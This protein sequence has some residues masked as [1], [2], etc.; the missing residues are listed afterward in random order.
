MKPI[1]RVKSKPTERVAGIDVS[2]KTLHVAMRNLKSEI[3]TFEV[4]NDADGHA[5]L[6]RRL[7]E[8]GSPA[9]VVLEAT[10]NY[11]LDAALSLIAA[12]I[13]VMVANPAATRSF[14]NAMMQRAKTDRVDSLALL[15]FA[16]RMEFE[17]WTPPSTAR[18]SLRSYAR[19]IHS[20]TLDVVALQNRVHALQATGTTPPPI[21][22]DLKQAIVALQKRIDA[23]IAEATTLIEAHP[24]LAK[25]RRHVETV[26]GI[27][28]KSAIQLLG[29]LLVLPADMTPNQVVAHAGLDPRPKRSGT[30]VKGRNAISKVG[31]AR[32]RAALYM[33]CLVA[34]QHCPP[35]RAFYQRLVERGK[36]K[37]VA[38]I[39]A[40]RRV[41]IAVWQMIRT[42]QDFDPT[43]FA[44]G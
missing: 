3:S 14:M 10:G 9:R 13:K 30:S 18:V 7:T 37:M 44:A 2:A 15:E 19:H 40:N 35:I 42:G 4:A 1:Q 38:L 12:K 36:L 6:V 21:L 16:E 5:T 8:N 33:P 20:L 26:T 43:R 29:E 25:A 11:S 34:I 27:K 41:L 22:T 32:L 24:D 31:N 23:M 17:P 39:A 28:T